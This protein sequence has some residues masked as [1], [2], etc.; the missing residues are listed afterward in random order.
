MNQILLGTIASLCAGLA[1]GLGAVPAF[2]VRRV[3]EA[4]LDASLGFAAGAMLFVICEE[5]IPGRP[6]REAMAERRPLG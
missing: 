5:I 1:T 2:F 6:M 4:L 3:S